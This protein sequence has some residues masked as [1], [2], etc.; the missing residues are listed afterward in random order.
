MWRSLQLSGEANC[1][2]LPAMALAAKARK[3]KRLGRTGLAMCTDWFAACNGGKRAYRWIFPRLSN[4]R[5]VGAAV[6]PD[7]CVRNLYAAIK[8]T[9][10]ANI[11]SAVRD[12]RR[13]V[14][15]LAAD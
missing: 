15:F 14:K 11:R 10:L 7:Q 12:F 3:R 5:L 6:L 1:H 9:M 2:P 13:P 4:N 8:A